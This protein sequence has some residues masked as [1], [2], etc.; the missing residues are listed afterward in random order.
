MRIGDLKSNGAIIDEACDRFKLSRQTVQRELG[1]VYERLAQF[2][3]ANV[4]AA[5]S[6]VL[7]A[8]WRLAG[9]AEVALDFRAAVV[10]LDKIAKVSGLH[11]PDKESLSEG[12]AV[13]PSQPTPK[14]NT[15]RDRIRALARDP[16][17]RERA[18][19]LGLDMDT[20]DVPD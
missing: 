1:E 19:K 9:M 20:I 2:D 7:E 6:K 8:L 17:V 10:A 4:G 18:R 15:V 13:D 16:S 5:R 12:P 14:A 3:R 11:Q